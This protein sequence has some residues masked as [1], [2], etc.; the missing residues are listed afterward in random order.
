M[1][2]SLTLAA[3]MGLLALSI[4]CNNEESPRDPIIHAI[5][6]EMNNEEVHTGYYYRDGIPEE[7]EVPIGFRS[8]PEAICADGNNI[9][10]GGLV[11]EI[12]GNVVG[13]A[14]V[15][16]NGQ[17]IEYTN[18]TNDASVA[19]LQVVKGKVYAV[20]YERS[21]SVYRAV[22]WRD[23]ESQYLT[24]GA[25]SAFA[26]GVFVDGSD[27]YVT[28][29]EFNSTTNGYEPKLWKNGTIT[30]ISHENDDALP[31]R[32]AVHNNTVYIAGRDNFEAVLWTNNEREALDWGIA[33]DI[34]VTKEGDIYMTLNYSDEG[35][36]SRAQYALNGE[37]FTLESESS[38]IYAM[39]VFRGI[40]YFIANVN[41]G[42][43]LWVNEE[44]TTYLEGNNVHVLDMI[45]N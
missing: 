32:I 41:G 42:A 27:V 22:L 40:P 30:T 33:T 36:G 28:L 16:K 18:G 31:R 29:R 37:I 19:H 14:A 9:Y 39:H 10:I 26:Y 11:Y 1:K 13:R 43:D 21:G 15:W 5:T 3:L 34:Q 25:T 12:E 20:G 8:Y 24:S 23:G 45:V 7:L 17:L 44:R 35:G 38:D 6:V 4:G 2:K